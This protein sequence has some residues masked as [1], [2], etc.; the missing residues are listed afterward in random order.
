MTLMV[1]ADPV[2][3]RTD[4]GGAIRVGNTRVTLDIIVAAYQQGMSP[5]ELVDELPTLE[6]ADVYAV[7]T[8]YLRHRTEVDDYLEEQ[9]QQGEEIRAKIE[10]LQGADRNGV[11]ERLLA[12]RAHRQS[13][14]HDTSAGG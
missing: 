9:R 7:I 1:V 14:Q 11:R 2:P 12:L 6:L 8:F 4:A 5:E 13:Q 10:A 3:L